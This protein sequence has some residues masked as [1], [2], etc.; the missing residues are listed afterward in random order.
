MSSPIIKIL[1]AHQVSSE[2]H[3]HVSMIQPKGKFSFTRQDLEEFWSIYCNAINE[4]ENEDIIVGIAEKP[5]SYLPVL[6]DVDIRVK[7]SDEIGDKLYTED[8]VQNV[9]QVYQSVL[10]SIVDECVDENLICILLEKDLYRITKGDT[11]YVKNGF[12]LHFPN[13]IL[14]KADQEVHLIPRVQDALN[15]MN[16]F[17]DIGFDNSG[18]VIDKSCCKVPWLLYGSRK[19]EEMKAYKVTKVFNSEC[20]EISIKKALSAYQ[21]FD[22][23][24]NLIDIKSKINYYLPRILS[25]LPFGREVK[26]TVRGLVPP[27][28]EKMKKEKEKNA[29]PVKKLSVVENLTITKKLLPLL[30]NFRCDDRNEWMTIGWI[31]YNIGETSHEALELW[32]EFSARSE[33]YDEAV[34]IYEWD[35]MVAKDLTLGTLKYYASVDSPELYLEFKKEQITHY[36]KESLNGSHNDIAKALYEDYGTTFVCASVVNRSWFHFVNHK[37]EMIEDGVFLREKISGEIVQ[38][39][40]DMGKEEFAKV[41]VTTD[42]AEE[43]MHN[44]RLKTLQKMTSSLKSAPYKSNV[45]KECLEVFYDRRFREKLDTNPYI[46]AFRNGVY[47]LK[48][49]IFRPGRPEDFLSKSLPIVYKEHQN[50]D[51]EV[52]NVYSFLE[53]VFPDKSIRTYFMDMSSDVFVGGNQQKVVLF[54]TGEGDNGKSVTQSIFEK[55]LGELAIKFSTTLITGKKTSTGSA[56]PELSR[57]GGGVRWA[58]LE[59][60]DGDEQINI[61]TLK[62]LSGN[63]SYWARDLFEKGKDTREIQPLFKLIFI[64]LAGNTSVSLSS[65]IS[66]SIEKMKQMTNVLSWDS[67]T[68]GLVSTNQ[69]A[70][71]DK[72]EQECIKLT[73]LD[74]R[75]IT[76][77]P[78][79]KF[80]TNQ[81]KWIEAK[82]I[83]LNNTQLKM[84]IDNPKC[85]D[86]FDNCEYIFT[87][88]NIKFNM[89]NYTDRIKASALC[90]I[91]G[92]VIT[93]GSQNKQLYMGHKIDAKSIVDDIELLTEK[94]PKIS[95]NNLVIKVNLPTELS[96]EITKIIHV[97]RGGKVNNKMIIPDFIF[98]KSCPIFLI[99]EII[100]GMFGGDGVLPS[101]VK[102]QCTMIQLVASKTEKHVQSLVDI[103]KKLSAVLL[104]RFDIESIVSEPKYYKNYKTDL[105]GDNKYNVFLRICK[106][107]S[108]LSFIEKIGVRHCCHKS[109]RLTAIS[110]ILRYKKS[111][112]KQSQLV[113]DRTR[114]L[115][116]KY[117]RQNPKDTIIQLSKDGIINK[118]KSTQIA[119]H[120]TGV[121]HSTIREA[122]KRN[123]S[124][125]G[126][127]W[128]SEKQEGEILDEKGCERIKDAYEQAVSEIREK[129]GFSDENS[130]VSLSKLRSYYLLYNHKYNMPAYGEDHLSKYL[131][132]TGLKNFCNNHRTI[133]HYSVD[134]DRESLPCYQMS[135][136]N[137]TNAGQKHVYDINVDE[138]YSNFIAEGIV[139]HNCNKLP[140]MK[141][142]D[143]ATW[144]RIRVIPFESTFCR[145]EDPAPET[146]EEQLEQ[147][148]FPMDKEFSKKIPGMLQAFAWVLL[149]HRKKITVRIEPEKVRMATALYRKQNDIYRQFVEECILDHSKSCISLLELY[150]HFKDWFRDSLPHH[151]VPIKNEVKEYFLKLWGDSDPGCTWTGYRIRSL[152]DDI[153]AGDAVVLDEEDLVNYEEGGRHLPPI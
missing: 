25:I 70:F 31:L 33:K 28:K 32:L 115:L 39:Y 135:V 145:P 102:K 81:N 83:I 140:K 105:S 99:R 152:A 16:V 124:S 78:N 27:I 123:G 151:T 120:I 67:N 121:D 111:I 80:L 86:I 48:D 22:M 18:D 95:Q 41:A 8:H 7:E 77:T 30:S 101:V 68:D 43:A 10:R 90:R 103:F 47:D 88:G 45:M 75:E 153:A 108:I 147:K 55:M 107:D 113:I 36:I 71:I 35:R 60:P 114:E 24:E 132:N 13:L 82:D 87:V 23:K 112:N 96:N 57:A 104:E 74:G 49:N 84:G 106:N 119:Q 93:D 37:W 148:R 4:D 5:Q 62:S 127:L 79:H 146:Y 133:H 9:I 56:N 131:D 29:N 97:Q 125:G 3:T 61:G 69:H 65:G 117:K 20:N 116:D 144:N 98:D 50:D 14:S 1:N 143:K 58:V 136:I 12:H 11:T 21:L 44:S 141:Y 73:L 142:S 6:V 66:V 26:E 126:F 85:D 122:I 52:H 15:E 89:E 38:K 100:A 2:H 72:G 138:H 94:R 34:C 19:S 59:E 54:W 46:I 149:E 109:Y 40:I 128:I 53:K 92:Y 129:Y 137:I 42:K 130:I 139:T 76:C 64:C 110:S 51:E 63:D 91:I 150:T 118:F 17:G 134:V